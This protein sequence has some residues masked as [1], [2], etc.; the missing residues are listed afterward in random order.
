MRARRALR[1]KLGVGLAKYNGE[2]VGAACF[3][4][5]KKDRRDRDFSDDAR[6]FSAVEIIFFCVRIENNGIGGKLFIEMQVRAT[7]TQP[8]H[9]AL[10]WL[11]LTMSPSNVVRRTLQ[12]N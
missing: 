9:A 1:A 7:R 4:R 8:K 2:V 11:M 3:S 5:V 10:A 12:L 6:G